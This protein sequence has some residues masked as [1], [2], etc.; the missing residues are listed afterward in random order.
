LAIALLN[1]GCM[2]RV[3]LQIL[4]DF[5]PIGYVLIPFSGMIELLAVAIYTGFLLT[6]PEKTSLNTF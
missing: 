3:I 5:H 6:A 1:L 2:A 4:T